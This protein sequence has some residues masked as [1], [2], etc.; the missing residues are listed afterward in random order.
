MSTVAPPTPF[1][2]PV[3]LPRPLLWTVDEFHRVGETGAF[4]GRRAI[5]IRGV[6][7]EQGPMNP[8][9]AIA[10]ELATETLRAAFGPGWRTRVQLPLVLGTDTDPMPDL[11]MVPG[12]PRD[13]TSHPTTAA[14]VVEVSD[15][16]LA[17]DM[18][19]RAEQYA[20]AGI[21]D[22]WVLDL[23]GRRLLVFR[24]PAPIT[25]GGHSYR[26][27]LTLGPADSVAPLA[28]PSVTVAVADLL[29]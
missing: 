11:S 21:A 16:T 12:T 6:I 20:E 13:S 3:P 18:T 23:V 9:H 5:L 17:L 25:A 10:V 1:P 27:H 15:T 4:K 28:A 14:L 29:P 26:T 8:P 2:T 7:L 24:D 22:Y 19:T